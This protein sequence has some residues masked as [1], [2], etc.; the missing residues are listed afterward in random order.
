M[1][2]EHN[3]NK[4]PVTLRI[5]KSVSRLLTHRRVSRSNWESEAFRLKTESVTK[6]NIHGI[7]K[8]SAP[9]INLPL[10]GKALLNP[11]SS[12][13]S[14]KCLYPLQA[15]SFRVFTLMINPCMRE[16]LLQAHLV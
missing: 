6:Q 10:T 11:T 15:Q 1:R 14:N 3:E 4:I 9:A 5:T 12:V 8:A 16:S 2:Q 13:P 7:R